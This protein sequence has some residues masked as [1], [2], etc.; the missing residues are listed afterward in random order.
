MRIYVSADHGGFELKQKIMQEMSEW[1]VH[2]DVNG[3]DLGAYDLIPDDDY[4][5]YAFNLAKEVVYQNSIG[6]KS[7]GI[8]VC[9]SGIG[10]SIAANKVKGCFA[11]LCFSPEHAT[12]AREH[13]NANV[14]VLDADYN[15]FAEHLAIIISFLSSEFEG[16][17]HACRVEMI[18]DFETPRK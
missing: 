15:T 1:D 18:S 2:E 11:A 6:E 16:G 14:L 7:F 3:Y 4:P 17:R 9:R 12:K 8:L 5:P 13:N 10:M